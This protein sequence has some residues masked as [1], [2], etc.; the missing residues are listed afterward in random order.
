MHRIASLALLPVLV[1]LLVPASAS[2]SRLK[3]IGRWQ[4]VQSNALIG[5][6]LVVG[7]QGTGDGGEAVRKFVRN[8]NMRDAG[9]LLT[10]DFRTRNAAVVA[11]TATLPPFARE[12]DAVDVTVAAV[13]DAASLSGGI[14]LPT[15]LWDAAGNA[16]WVLA[17]GALSVGGFSAGANGAGAQKNHVTTARIP[18]GGK[19]TQTLAKEFEGRT[20][21]NFSLA[22]ADFTTAVRTARVINRALLGDF[23]H[24]S[25][26]STIAVLVPPQYQGRVPEMVA[27]LE[28]TS[29]DT[30]AMAKVVV[31]ERTGTV[32]MGSQVRIHTVAVAH[33][34]LTIQVDT[35]FGVSQPEAFSRGTTEVVANSDV[36][37]TEEGGDLT[38]LGGVS[39]GEVVGALNQLGVTPRDLISIL[40]AIHGAGAMDAELEVL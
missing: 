29:V 14:L 16:D 21:L 22:R 5:H 23:A 32:V 10:Q 25:D 38:V 8:M 12:G 15:L 3:D 35:E 39:I 27:L 11:V 13:Q 4:G 37:V 6:G 18:G 17:A 20:E 2:A 36:R 7:L 26:S 33:A 31:N 19:V 28:N 34:G 24:A 1:A 9:H 30:D 40:Q